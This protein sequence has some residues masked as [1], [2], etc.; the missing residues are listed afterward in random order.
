MFISFLLYFFYFEVQIIFNSMKNT[1]S[2]HAYYL[3]DCIEE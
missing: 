3:F 1:Y 2:N